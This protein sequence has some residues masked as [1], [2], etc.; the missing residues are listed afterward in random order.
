MMLK[1]IVD[2][3]KEIKKYRISSLASSVTF[4]FIINGGSLFFLLAL[5]LNLF[6]IEFK[7]YV[8]EANQTLKTII[9]Y[10]ETNANIYYRP[11]YFILTI[12]SLWSSST[13]FYH[14][15]GVGELIYQKKRKAYPF[16]Y[17]LVSILFVFIFIALLLIAFIVAVFTSY[18][19]IHLKSFYLR[20]CLRLI[21]YLI[22]PLFVIS[23]FMLFVPPIRL[24]LKQV[25][26]G[27][28]FTLVSFILITVGFRIYLVIFD[29]YKAIYG[30]LTFLIIGMIYIYLLIYFLIIG[31]LINMLENRKIKEKSLDKI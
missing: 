13:L 24:K 16:F 12:T 3:Y 21:L 25:K 2:Y 31:L 10:F 22:I 9:L 30:A 19:L 17:R 4:F 5:T 26:K 29:K 11:F 6:N 7:E 27:M 1:K 28:Y 23:F 8:L 15:I 18:L 14:I 20:L